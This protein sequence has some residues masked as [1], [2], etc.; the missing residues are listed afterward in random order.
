M[1]DSIYALGPIH[2]KGA[3]TVDFALPG[4][5]PLDQFPPVIRT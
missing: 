3:V 1:H 2:A 4:S 5:L